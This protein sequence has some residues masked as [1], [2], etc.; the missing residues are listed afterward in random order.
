MK[1]GK[2]IFAAVALAVALGVGALALAPRSRKKKPGVDDVPLSDVPPTVSNSPLRPGW[3]T[4]GW[5]SY[6]G[7]APQKMWIRID[8]TDIIVLDSGA[9]RRVWRWTVIVGE[10]TPLA[11][12]LHVSGSAV[13]DLIEKLESY[14]IDVLGF[15][16]LPIPPLELLK[17]YTTDSD[18]DIGQALAA[19][20][21]EWIDTAFAPQAGG[22]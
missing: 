18:E 17:W 4:Y 2:G 3:H 15:P 19:E 21:A 11:T 8:R 16:R 10:D 13:P 9:E 22:V 6:Q 1:R 20:A 7:N 14:G 5:Y 12:D